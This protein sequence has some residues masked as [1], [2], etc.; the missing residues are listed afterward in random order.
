MQFKQL[1]QLFEE[2]EVT[3]SRL[4]MTDILANSIKEMSVKEIQITS[5][6]IQGRVAP[7]FVNSEFN[8]SEKSILTMLGQYV[9]GKDKEINVSDIR[10]KS[11]DIG[12]SVMQIWEKVAHKQSSISIE[13]IYS[14]LWEIVNAI[15]NG[16]IARKNKL[17]INTLTQLSPIEAKYFVRIVCGDLRLGLS[18]K[19][20]IDAFSVAIV[21]DKSIKP[22]L[23]SAY[24]VSADIGY[25]AK[26]SFESNKKDINT[27]LE[28][29][30]CIPGIP[31]LS[32]LVERV[33]SFEEIF[34]RFKG[35]VQLQPK[36]DGLRCQI[37]KWSDGNVI[38]HISIWSD[39]IKK[40]EKGFGLFTSRQEDI[41]VR[42]FTRNL[43]DVTEMFPEI[44]ES[45]KLLPID[46]FVLDSEVV[47]WN[48][49]KDTFLSYQETMQRR[50]KYSVGEKREVIP[51]KAMVFDL[52]YLEGESLISI[53]TYKRVE[54]L[55][56]VFPDTPKGIAIANTTL[57][58]EI[59]SLKQY[60]N[61]SVSK[62][63]E[64]IIVKQM[65]GGYKPGVRNYEWIKIKKSI[66]KDLVDTLDL[67]IVGFY[68]GS[69]RRSTFGLGAVLAAVYNNEFDTFDTIT[70]VGTGMTDKDLDIMF[71]ALSKGIVPKQPKEVRT[72]D[73][74]IPDFWVTPK[75]VIS[76]EADEITKKISKSKEKIGGGLSL[77]FPRLIEFDRDKNPLDITSVGEL[78]NL[79]EI[80]TKK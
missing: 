39:Y 71:E 4:E 2:I 43:E 25:I 63:L 40:E 31:V 24:G 36:F 3:P 60:F 44:V 49:E 22:S 30:K 74:L 72:D 47:G 68:R 1:A 45:A 11:G 52:L 34:E 57:S 21:G 12:D 50:R 23:E 78:E 9:R 35:T 26:I 38:S 62:G 41:Q 16:S 65:E 28:N 5:Y 7:M 67:V 13:Q 61:E 20:L 27:S 15:G 80:S 42:L 46:S 75:Y 17:V 32:R 6:M 66:D 14:I 58:E 51:V 77:R 10:N 53:D 37:H 59:V 29:I 64:G 56:A 48:Y 33:G 54:I 19:T 76:V 79:Y 73:I 70:K 69:G 18:I 55:Q 8:Y